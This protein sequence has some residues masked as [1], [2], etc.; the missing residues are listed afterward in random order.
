MP[1]IC[2]IESAPRVPGD[3]LRGKRP[4]DYGRGRV[5]ALPGCTTILRRTHKG[6]V[7]DP[8]INDAKARARASACAAPAP[9]TTA[10][11]A[12][13]ATKEEKVPRDEIHNRREDVLELMRDGKW[14]TAKEVGKRL[15]VSRQR[16]FTM[17]N[18]LRETGH[19]FEARVGQGTRLVDEKL[20][21]HSDEGEESAKTAPAIPPAPAPVIPPP[22]QPA[23]EAPA[24]ESLPPQARLAPFAGITSTMVLGYGMSRELRI[25]SGLEDLDD[26]T[27]ER[28]LG[29]AFARWPG[30]LDIVREVEVRYPNADRLATEILDTL[31]RHA[32]TA[33]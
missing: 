32:R 14:W 12:I 26:A 13:R 33:L 27:R 2:H 17:T 15:G 16:V 6:P 3:S 18:E 29:Y 7:C 19:V 22:E 21:A 23:D 9:A 8:C 11:P 20:R 31:D 30:K 5:C 25:L 4:H 28:V 1:P 24:S 10:A